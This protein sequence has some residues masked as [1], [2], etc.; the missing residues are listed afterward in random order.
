MTTLGWRQ[1]TIASRQ[2]IAV[3]SM[4]IPVAASAIR[5]LNFVRSPR[6]DCVDMTVMQELK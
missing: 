6:S 2:D 1:F 4:R 3:P 5:D